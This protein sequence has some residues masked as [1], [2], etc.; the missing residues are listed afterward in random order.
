MPN[1]EQDTQVPMANDKMGKYQKAE[2]EKKSAI[3][4]VKRKE[5]KEKA[6]VGERKTESGKRAVPD[7]AK[8]HSD[9]WR[10]P[11][12]FKPRK[13]I[14]VH[15]Y[16]DKIGSA[17]GGQKKEDSEPKIDYPPKK[18]PSEPNYWGSRM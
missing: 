11:S 1:D 18:P 8:A 13:N 9:S 14:K 2:D 16:S 6:E 10:E 3:R 12:I 4:M 17:D 5:K 15:N 7:W